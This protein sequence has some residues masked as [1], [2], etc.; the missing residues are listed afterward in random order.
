MRSENAS[1]LLLNRNSGLQNRSILTRTEFK[2]SAEL[3]NP[4][5][6]SGQSHAHVGSGEIKLT[7]NLFRDSL[8][9]IPYSQGHNAVIPLYCDFDG[10]GLGMA[11][12]IGERFLHDTEE[13]SF[14]A[15]RQTLP[16]LGHA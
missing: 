16:I 5:A 6:N 7:E 15:Y 4:F 13:R 2:Y 14:N 10:F 8:A 1:C 12:N 11:M 9:K 3:L